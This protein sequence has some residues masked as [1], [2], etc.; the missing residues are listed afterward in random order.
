[1]KL[2]EAFDLKFQSTAKQLTSQKLRIKAAVT[3]ALAI[4]KLEAEMNRFNKIKMETIQKYAEKDSDGKLLSNED[5]TMKLSP[6]DQTM[7]EAQL[8]EMVETEIEI[9]TVKASDLGEDVTL[10]VEELLLL[11]GLVTFT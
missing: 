8:V 9:P 10:S 3:L 7:I 11:K 1:M 4:E 5:G 2:K 6:E